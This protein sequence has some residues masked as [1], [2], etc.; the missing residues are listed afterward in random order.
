MNMNEFF[1]LDTEKGKEAL[2]VEAL[3]FSVQ[4]KVHEALAEVGMS[5]RELAE[6]IGVSDSLVSQWLSRKGANLTVKTLARIFHALDD[7][8]CIER[9][10][11]HERERAPAR[12]NRELM[13]LAHGLV[14]K[15]SPWQQ[16]CSNENRA[17]QQ[18][19]A[20]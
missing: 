2:A 1:G 4:L 19:L 10:S 8:V 16:R 17:P 15:E 18:V 3:I 14:E 13:S 9:R 12:R 7:A 20:A 5:Q 11:V 6:R